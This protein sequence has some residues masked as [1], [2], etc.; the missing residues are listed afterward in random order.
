MTEDAETRTGFFTTHK[1]DDQ[2]LFE[3]P[4]DV[5]GQDLLLV[6]E[7]AETA[8]GIGYGGQSI[9]NGVYRWEKQAS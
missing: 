5:L 4:T 2:L 1:I 3:I 8:L 7:I 9:S 6:I